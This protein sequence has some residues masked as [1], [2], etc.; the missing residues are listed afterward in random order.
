MTLIGREEINKLHKKYAP[1]KEAYNSIW[2][3]CQI[4]AEIAEEIASKFDNVNKELITVGALLHDIGVYKIYSQDKKDD[5]IYITHGIEGYK[6][7]KDEKLDESIC[8][9]AKYHTGVGITKEDIIN[10]NLP[11]PLADYL[12]ETIEE[13]IVA[14]ADKFHSKSKSSNFNSPES[15]S[16]YIGNKLGKGKSI[17]FYEM[18][19]EF[20]IPDLEVLSKKYNQ[21]IK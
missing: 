20:G 21:E 10:N 17:I 7:L 5:N 13:K 6:I 15:Y 18:V 1:S 3:H 14:Y 19:K 2:T 4:V 12:P 16:K 11:L 9:F 8:R